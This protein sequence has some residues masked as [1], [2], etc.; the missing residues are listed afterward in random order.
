[1][2]DDC[3]VDGK[4]PIS[5]PQRRLSF[6]CKTSKPVFAQQSSV[7]S[8]TTSRDDME[9]VGRHRLDKDLKISWQEAGN[10]KHISLLLPGMLCFTNSNTTF[11]SKLG[12]DLLVYLPAYRWEEPTRYTH[13]LLPC[14]F[15]QGSDRICKITSDENLTDSQHFA[16]KW[17]CQE[18]QG[19]KILRKMYE[20][21]NDW[22]IK[23]DLCGSHIE[24][25][26][27]TD[28]YL[29]VFYVFCSHEL[30]KENGPLIKVT[31]IFVNI[32]YVTLLE[33]K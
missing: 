32:F 24:I 11:K 6:D 33:W 17:V 8:H 29:E 21:C 1:M 3:R 18:F 5:M 13:C 2:F 10:E 31:L 19:N 22:E 14:S 15:M 25:I 20:D 28:H 23:P 26:V 4:D 12:L 9:K 16:G 30:P 7:L 27:R